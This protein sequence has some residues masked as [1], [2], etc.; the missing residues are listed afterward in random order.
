MTAKIGRG[1]AIAGP[2]EHR[3]EESV[4]GAQIAHTRNENDQRAF[5]VDVVGDAA[6]GTAQIAGFRAA[7]CGW[8]L[9]GGYSS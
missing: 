8:G 4:R 6:I 2:T 7:G 3:G 9:H 5:S 1:D